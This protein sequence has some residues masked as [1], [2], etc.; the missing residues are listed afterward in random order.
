MLL[1]RDLNIPGSL[2]VTDMTSELVRYLS[3]VTVLGSQYWDTFKVN[4]LESSFISSKKSH[5]L[6]YNIS[7]N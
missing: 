5:L 1:I 6:C 3:S 7:G 2:L 4:L